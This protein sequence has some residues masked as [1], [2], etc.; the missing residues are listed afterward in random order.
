MLLEF[1]AQKNPNYSTVQDETLA[2]DPNEY[3]QEHQNILNTD[4]ILLA[5][6][7]ELDNQGCFKAIA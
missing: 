2:V 7:Q 4:D 3:A 6:L 5:N 1:V